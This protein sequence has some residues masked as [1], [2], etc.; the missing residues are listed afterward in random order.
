VLTAAEPIT[1]MSEALSS[2]S[3][4]QWYDPWDLDGGGK[5]VASLTVPLRTARRVSG[6]IAI[7]RGE[8]DASDRT[9]KRRDEGA[10]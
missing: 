9:S 1:G 6:T 5:V 3:K 10:E 2:R 4:V 8:Q 7:G